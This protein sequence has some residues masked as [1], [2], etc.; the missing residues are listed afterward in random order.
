[1]KLNKILAEKGL[2][3]TGLHKVRVLYAEKLHKVEINPYEI[4]PIKS[5][6]ITAAEHVRYP[7]KY[8]DRSGINTLFAQKEDCDDILMTQ[9]GFITDTSYANV[10]LYDGSDW[11]TPAAPMLRG[12]R[13]AYLLET[14]KIKSSVIRVKDLGLFQ[15]IRLLNGMIP[16][17]EAPCILV[18]DVKL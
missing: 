1:M 9:H 2:P 6:K 16:W 17:E 13:R 8:A 3:Q 7:K 18:E 5:L 15:E 14:G 11:Y 4:K 10:A 12:T